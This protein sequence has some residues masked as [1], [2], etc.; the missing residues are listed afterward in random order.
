MK[1]SLA[2]LLLISIFFSPE[3]RSPQEVVQENLD[4]YNEGDIE[5]F[6]KSF[7][8]D[9]ALYEF[10]AKIASYTG[11]KQIREVYSKLFKDSPNLHSTIEH[12]SVLGNKVIDHEL[13]VGRK[14][15]SD[16][17]KLIMVYEVREDKIFKMTVIR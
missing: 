15:S 6:M 4:Y 13:I 14:G 9:I 8:D 3:T 12:R 1:T 7:T 17:L 2:I 11:K 10:G 5:G 16:T